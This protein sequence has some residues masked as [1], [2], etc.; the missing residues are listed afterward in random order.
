MIY[1]SKIWTD[2]HRCGL[3]RVLREILGVYRCHHLFI[4]T[5]CA[6]HRFQ[7]SDHSV[8]IQS[9]RWE[10]QTEGE[11][12]VVFDL[13]FLSTAPADFAHIRQSERLSC[14]SNTAKQG[15]L[16]DDEK[17][18]YKQIQDEKQDS[19]C[20]LHEDVYWRGGRQHSYLKSNYLRKFNTLIGRIFILRNFLLR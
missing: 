12:Q 6:A 14:Y 8:S 19:N 16:S 4:R 2:M 18:C 7:Y 3:A 9:C 11:Q 20:L 1:K 10:S 5:S 13:A 17:A 15:R